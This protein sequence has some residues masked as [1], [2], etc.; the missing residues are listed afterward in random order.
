ML[1]SCMLVYGLLV[2][3]Y[4]IVGH[5]LYMVESRAEEHLAYDLRSL[6][7][8]KKVGLHLVENQTKSK[9]FQIS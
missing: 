3:T 1:V 7:F 5:I 4:Q 6:Q 2:T 9:F 8:V